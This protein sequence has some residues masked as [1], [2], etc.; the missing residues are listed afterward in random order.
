MTALVAPFLI[1]C[2][3]AT[4]DP[5]FSINAHTTYYRFAEGLPIDHPMSAAE[6][7]RLKFAHHP[8]GAFDLVINGLFVEPFTTKWSTFDFWVRGLRIVLSGAA[9][10][11]LALWPFSARGRLMLVILIGSLVPYAL[12][13]NIKGGAEWRFT[14]HVLPIL[15]VAA[16][17]A[18]AGVLRAART[19]PAMRPLVLRAVAACAI[20]AVAAASYM[21]LPWFIANE[22]IASGEPVT[23]E[24]GDRERVFYRQGWSPRHADGV[25]NVR[26]SRAA[27]TSVHIPLPEKRPYEVVLR[28]DPVAPDRQDFVAVLLTGQLVG[29]IRLSWDPQRVGSH[30]V[31]L[32]VE[33]VKVGDN[34]ITLVPETTVTAGSAGARFAWLDP[35]DTIGVR[36]WYVRVLK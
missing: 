19:R 36:M 35:A 22:A 28:L 14:M 16:V 3:I 23:I 25:V 6:Y 24:A 13:W 9:L 18:V 10:A 11:G 5:F 27:R 1:S 34:E 2:A 21:A 7:V 12:T 17:G 26:V 4:G 30:R 29:R 31:A 20:A 8:L 15:L 33:W 32:P